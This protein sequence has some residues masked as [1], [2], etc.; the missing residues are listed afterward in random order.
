MGREMY[1]ALMGW[2]VSLMTTFRISARAG[3]DRKASAARHR[4]RRNIN[5][6]VLFAVE[7]CI[8]PL[9]LRSGQAFSSLRMT[10]ICPDESIV[11][12]FRGAGVNFLGCG[13]G[14]GWNDRTGRPSRQIRAAGDQARSA[15]VGNIRPGPLNED[16]QP[17]AKADEK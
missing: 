10:K 4:I 9:R 3:N 16:Q 2:M 17:V 1:S 8:G 11:P 13:G 12:L 15:F 6:S 5:E 7:A 14:V